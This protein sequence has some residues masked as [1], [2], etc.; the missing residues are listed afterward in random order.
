MDD[1]A[2]KDE[3]NVRFSAAHLLQAL[4]EERRDAAAA[5]PAP[6]G[7]DLDALLARI[8]NL[9]AQVD[10]ATEERRAAAA[11]QASLQSEMRDSDAARTAAVAELAALRDARDDAAHAHE[12]E[13]AEFRRRLKEN[14]DRKRAAEVSAR[15]KLRAYETDA[16][17]SAAVAAET[18]RKVAASHARKMSGLEES[19]R[20]PSTPPIRPR[21]RR[22]LQTWQ[23]VRPGLRPFKNKPRPRPVRAQRRARHTAWH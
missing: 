2:L 1:A 12:R 13:L 9:H 3:V 14:T 22:W 15:A 5:T 16:A 8:D 18:A 6:T 7:D 23:R 17:E 19:A 11:R 4:E 10:A 21:S 20:R